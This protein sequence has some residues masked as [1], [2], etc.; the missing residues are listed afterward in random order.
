LLARNTCCNYTLEKKKSE[1]IKTKVQEN[2]KRFCQVKH[3]LQYVSA[4][5]FNNIKKS[6]SEKREKMQRKASLTIDEQR[7]TLRAKNIS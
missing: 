2:L 1:A 4:M 5:C 3:R 7:A 6:G